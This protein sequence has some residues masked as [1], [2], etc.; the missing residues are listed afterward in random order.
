MIL[1]VGRLLGHQRRLN[2]TA[3]QSVP[4]VALKERVSLN[5]P[6][7]VKST[8]KSLLWTL[9]EQ[10]IHQFLRHSALEERWELQPGLQDVSEDLVLLRL[11]PSSEGQTP[12]HEL[13]QANTQRPIVSVHVVALPQDLLRRHE[14]RGPR[15]GERV[16]VVKLFRE[17]KINQLRVPRHV[18]QDILWL[19]VPVHDS[20]FV[21]ELQREQH[22]TDVELGLLV[23]EQ[24]ELVEGVQQLPAFDQ[25]GH[26]V[27]V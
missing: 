19:K 6:S 21:Q 12:T 2:A 18:K 27:E 11:W 25:L 5:V 7:T 9:G 16:T 22:G 15:E 1:P 10:A 3:E 20:P 17:T 13:I 24:T 8:A 26:E 23:G 4:V 14:V